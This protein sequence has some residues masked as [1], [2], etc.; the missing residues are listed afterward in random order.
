MQTIQ[1]YVDGQR[2]EMF[3][4][5]SIQLT[6][7][8][9]DVRDISKIFTDYSQTFN[10]PASK[11]NNKIFKH[12]YNNAIQNGY[13]ARFRSEAVI[14]LNHSPFRKGTIRL[15]RV[16]MKNNKP[17]SY[18]LTFFGSTVSLS[19][20]LG[21]DRL[22]N[23]DLS[24][25]NHEWTY[26]NV[27]NGLQTG[28]T[29]NG[30]SAAIIYPLLSPKRR[31]IFDSD[32]NY[33]PLLYPDNYANIGSALAGE[34]VYQQDLKPAIRL[35]RII[36]AIEDAYP[37]T[38]SR[39]FFGSSVFDDLYMWLHRN[40]GQIAYADG[41]SDMVISNWVLN[42]ED[43][44]CGSSKAT[45]FNDYFSFTST[46]S[47]LED[48]ID[49]DAQL[50]IT[51]DD[52]NA[53]YSYKIVDLISD[54]VLFEETNVSGVKVATVEMTTP[55]GQSSKDYEIQAVIST[56]QGSGFLLYDA[57]W[58]VR[59]YYIG[60]SG[61]LECLNEQTY[62][63]LNQNMIGEVIV[64]N[65][66][67]DLK[68]ID[69]LTGLFKMF[70]LTAY[71]NDSG[72]IVV[73]TLDNF[74]ATYNMH[75]ISKYVKVDESDIERVPLYGNIN[76]DFRDPST[77]LAVEFS[78]R[79]GQD[80][81]S[82]DF[83]VIID[84]EYIDG[85]DYDI[86]LPF[87][88]VI[89]ERLTDDFDG[90]ETNACYGWFVSENEDSIKGNPLLFFNVNETVGSKTIYF[91]SSDGVSQA[92]PA[93]YNRP[94]NVNSNETQTL[95]FDAE[96]DEFN[97]VFNYNSLFENYYKTYIESVFNQY[98]RITKI[99][100]LLPIKVLSK[101]SLNDRIVINDKRY[102]INS[103]SSNLMNGNSQLELIEDL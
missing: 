68:I 45:F 56:K 93:T 72:T 32:V 1:L 30:D 34:G 40:S 91:R 57:E 16:K 74:Y 65:Q 54:T 78:E 100:A 61:D 27:L 13:D 62:E 7:S 88:K 92:T 11:T 80:F 84:G 8:I 51:P 70:N 53:E 96:N 36:E 47:N 26:N 25:Y 73:D 46:F 44:P 101:Y 81:G 18:E 9:Q 41:G 35:I 58:Y 5:E 14:E 19:R 82:E 50:T 21:D 42:N 28:L 39:D 95:N 66:T 76:F 22:K 87:E 33:D 17:Y 64:A 60:R 10:V 23:L 37:L 31:F 90:V 48:Y 49:G 83:N 79:N 94:S 99:N 77:F 63:A 52:L 59:T 103:I 2:V 85:D 3:A 12:Y 89:Y 38:F 20:V 97:L 15:N 67:P 24:D 6:S 98:N 55:L 4:D 69:L 29:F 86:T 71:V 102:K 43:L 75:S